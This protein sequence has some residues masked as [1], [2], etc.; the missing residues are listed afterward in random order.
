M[1]AFHREPLV[2]LKVGSSES[3]WHRVM[4]TTPGMI[5]RLGPDLVLAQTACGDA[6]GA[7]YYATREESYEG[8]LCK[9]GCFTPA[10][11]ELAETLA[12][13]A[14]ER[15]E[16]LHRRFFEESE[17]RR[18]QRQQA[19]EEAAERLRRAKTN[20]KPEGDD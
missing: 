20:G 5:A 15:Q 11:L 9:K 7:G 14:E 2:Q 16:A 13:A 12:A 3:P 6:V 18:L 17:E 4:L 8:N 10:E 1:V 19:R